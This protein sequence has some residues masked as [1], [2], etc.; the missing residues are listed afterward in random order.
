MPIGTR[1][2]L[3]PK[4]GRSSRIPRHG[5][6]DRPQAYAAQQTPSLT[7]DSYSFPRQENILSGAIRRRE[8]VNRAEHKRMLDMQILG[9]LVSRA[10]V[11]GVKGGGFDDF[12][13]KMQF[14]LRKA[15]SVHPV[16]IDERIA[17]AAVSVSVVA[18]LNSTG[19]FLDLCQYGQ[20][21]VTR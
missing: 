5:L 18:K 14:A 8:E 17:K 2:P 10:A 21:A 7:D 12:V 4:A 6:D 13:K 20:N 15:S 1:W 3:Q 19:Y 9:L 11:E 16:P